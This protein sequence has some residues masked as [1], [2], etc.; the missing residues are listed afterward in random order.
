MRCQ[1]LLTLAF[2]HHQRYRTIA[3]CCCFRPRHV[4]LRH[5]NINTCLRDNPCH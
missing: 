2:G 5:T 4:H 3:G 1:A